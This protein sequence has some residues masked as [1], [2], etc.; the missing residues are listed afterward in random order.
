MV[1]GDKFIITPSEFWLEKVPIHSAV[2]IH[3]IVVD[4]AFS[5]NHRLLFEFSILSR[6]NIFE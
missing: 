5:S 2:V 1:W 4:Q 3:G 6:R